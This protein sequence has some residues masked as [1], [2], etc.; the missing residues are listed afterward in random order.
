MSRQPIRLKRF[1][2]NTS[3][4]AAVEFAMVAPLLA[5]ALVMTLDASLHV[6][7]RMRMESAVRA[8]VQYLMEDG[9]DLTTLENLVRTTWTSPPADAAVAAERY[10]LCSDVA[11]ACDTLCGD[12]SAPESYFSISV[13]GTLDGYLVDT[14]LSADEDVRVR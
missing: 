7:N 4:V 6:V 5:A 2:G 14:T 9:R 13:S 8:G 11:H 12:N 10:C 3:G 1:V